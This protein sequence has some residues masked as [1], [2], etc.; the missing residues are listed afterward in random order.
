MVENNNEDYIKIGQSTLRIAFH[1][2]K[3]LWQL[4]CTESNYR[5]LVK[6]M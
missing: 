6:S 3:K 2:N 5:E 1:S 4:S